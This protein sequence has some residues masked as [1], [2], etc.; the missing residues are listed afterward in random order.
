[1]SHIPGSVRVDHEEEPDLSQLG[2]SADSTGISH[3]H[4]HTHCDA[5]IIIVSQWCAI[6]LLGIVPASLHRS[7]SKLINS[8]WTMPKGL[9]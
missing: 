8:R 1:V 9:P 2:I 3:T 6:A 7:Y 5:T 4:Y